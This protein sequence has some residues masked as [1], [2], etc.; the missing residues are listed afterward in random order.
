MN[1]A[2]RRLGP[3]FRL[4]SWSVVLLLAGAANPARAQERLDAAAVDHPSPHVAD[5]HM[6]PPDFEGGLDPLGSAIDVRAR[7]GNP[8]A[9]QNADGT[10]SVPFVHSAP[11][12]LHCA[13]YD[14]GRQPMIVF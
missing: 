3:M 1:A 12:D 13:I 11:R 7:G 6:A 9:A 8:A 5:P 10:W 4:A 14:P 2:P